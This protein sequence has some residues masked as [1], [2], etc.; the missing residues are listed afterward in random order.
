MSVVFETVDGG[1]GVPW[2]F[3]LFFF[4]VTSFHSSLSFS[5]PLPR[6]GRSL[7]LSGPRDRIAS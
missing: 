2:M 7:D 5:S 3:L 6:S 1:V 4:S